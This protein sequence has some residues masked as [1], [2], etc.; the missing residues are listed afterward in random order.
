MID[1]SISGKDEITEFRK[2]YTNF[3]CSCTYRKPPVVPLGKG[4]GDSR[5]SNHVHLQIYLVLVFVFLAKV[6]L[7]IA[8]ENLAG[9]RIPVPFTIFELFFDNMDQRAHLS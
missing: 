3:I 6:G 2:R 8:M 7:P 1:D 5:G 9:R 4:D